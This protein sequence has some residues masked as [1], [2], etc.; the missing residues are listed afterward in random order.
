MISVVPTALG[1]VTTPQ[2]TCV[3]PLGKTSILSSASN[4]AFYLKIAK[5]TVGKRNLSNLCLSAISLEECLHGLC[6][7]FGREEIRMHGLCFSLALKDRMKAPL[8]LNWMID[9]TLSIFIAFPRLIEND[10]VDR[11]DANTVILG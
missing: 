11:V 1:E 10:A 6:I 8:F 2:T 9:E 4:F 7:V 5:S 3:W